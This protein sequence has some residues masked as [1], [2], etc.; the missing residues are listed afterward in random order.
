MITISCEASEIPALCALLRLWV[1]GDSKVEKKV[2]SEDTKP[3]QNSHPVAMG[4]YPANFYDA[5]IEKLKLSDLEEGKGPF[6]SEQKAEILDL[7]AS[8]MRP[9]EIAAK[10]GIRNGQRVQG[11]LMSG[12]RYKTLEN[13]A[14]VSV[15]VELPQRPVAEAKPPEAHTPEKEAD[16][17]NIEAD[18]MILALRKTGIPPLDIAASLGRSIGGAW[19]SGSVERRMRELGVA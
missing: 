12:K 15:P 13:A 11:F 17:V 4:E 5:P 10:M 1:Y 2:T 8:G 9:K 14:P 16:Q 19:T 18:R 3:L 6:S 7:A